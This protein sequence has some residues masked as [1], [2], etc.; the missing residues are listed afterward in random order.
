MSASVSVI[1]P[2]YNRRNVIEECLR[3]VLAQSYADFEVLVI[4]DGSTDQTPEVCRRLAAEDPRIRL[5]TGHHTGVSAARNQG[6]E[7]ASGEYL[8][9]LDSDDCIHP[10]LLEELVCG[11]KATGAAI[12][13]TGLVLIRDSNWGHTIPRH[14]ADRT[15]GTYTHHSNTEALRSF[16]TTTS[17]LNLIGGVMLRRD[18]V[19]DTR[20]RQDLHIG[21][22]FYFIY[23]NLLKGAD[24]VFL[25]KNRYYCRLHSANSSR[26]RSYAGFYSRFHRRVLVWQQEEALGRPQHAALQKRDAFGIYLSALPHITAKPERRQ[27]RHLLRQH[28]RAMLPHLSAAGKVRFLL[29]V[30]IPPMYRI[31]S[32]LEEKLRKIRK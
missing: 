29:S 6:L 21:E 25:E 20:F 2:V 19:G 31:L 9:F 18:L 24:A 26:D 13:G 12:A 30:Y 1:L 15:P 4:D 10:L 16:F 22:D 11:L 3:S 17:P 32:F 5:I 28:R 14:L 8:F 27:M 7:T 23:E